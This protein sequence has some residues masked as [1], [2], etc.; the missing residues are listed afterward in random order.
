[1]KREPDLGGTPCTADRRICEEHPVLRRQPDL[2]GTPCTAEAAGPARNTLYCGDSWTCE[3]HPVLR[4]QLDL[5]GT[6]CTAETAGSARNTLHSGDSQTYKEHPVLRRQ[7]DLRGTFCTAETAGSARNTQYCGDSRICEEHPVLRGQPDLRG[8]PFTAETAR[9]ARN[10]LYW[11][12]SR[13][14]EEHPVLQRQPDLR[15]TPCT[16]GTAGSVRNTL[17]CRDSRICEVHPVLQRE[18]DLRGTPCTVETARPIRNTLCCGDSRICEDH[19]VLRRQPD[20][21]GT[22]CTAEAAGP[23]RNTLYCR[24]S[25]T[26][27]EHS[28]LRRQPDLRGT[29]CTAE[30]AGP[31][32][33]TLYCR[34]SRTCEVH[35]VLQRQSD[36]RGTPCTAET[37]GPARNTLY[38]GDSWT[39]EGHPV[40]QRQPDL[41]GHMINSLNQ[42]IGINSVISVSFPGFENQDEKEERVKRILSKSQHK[43]KKQDDKFAERA[44]SHSQT[45]PSTPADSS[46]VTAEKVTFYSSPVISASSRSG[47]IN[48]LHKMMK[49]VILFTCLVATVFANPVRKVRD[50][51]TSQENLAGNAFQ[52]MNHRFY[53]TGQGY[54]GYNLNNMF[55][56]RFGY[57]PNYQYPNNRGYE[58]YPGYTNYNGHDPFQ[59][60]PNTNDNTQNIGT[61]TMAFSQEEDDNDD[62]TE[63]NLNVAVFNNNGPETQEQDNAQSTEDDLNQMNVAGTNQQIN[64]QSIEDDLNQMNVAGANQQID[65]QSTEG[66]LNQINVAGSNVNNGS[67]FNQDENGAGVNVHDSSKTDN[68]QSKLNSCKMVRCRHGRVC[69]LNE[70]GYP[71]CI[72]QEPTSCPVSSPELQQVCGTNNRTYGNSCQ[73]FASKCLLDGIKNGHIIHLDYVGPCKYIAPCLESELNEFPLRLR[74][75]LKNILVEMYERDLYSPGLLSP[76]EKTTVKKIYDFERHLHPRDYSLDQLVNDFSQNYQMY[77]YPVHW[78]FSQLDLHPMDGYL[79]HTELA[80]LRTPLIPLEHCTSRFF[81]GCDLDGDKD[82]SLREWSR[83]F[84]LKEEDINPNLV[85]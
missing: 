40:L 8:T 59:Q 84:G 49:T 74:G 67:D 47:E 51:S 75:W 25:W 76:K 39:C 45:D 44:A 13:T 85:F 52:F 27:E 30:T 54:P 4:R 6:P 73:F 71:T 56:G 3:E 11:G 61:N 66:D 20:L 10:T 41:Q 29:P 34:D 48:K 32:R 31:A 17:Y 65:T 58:P 37:A 82:I 42:P 69:K 57:S 38:C 81:G 80:P 23:A 68:I 15:G 21:G 28:V 24:G 60:Y 22:P 36:L 83:C 18:P 1:M 16:T 64:T 2:R 7:P 62:G 43:P 5:R 19:P 46:P 26:C 9:S 53:Q 55:P 72:C 78:Q 77:I 12:D 79:S 14:C 50:A 35:P 33:D 70:I 63:S